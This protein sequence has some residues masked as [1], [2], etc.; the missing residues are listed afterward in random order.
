[1]PAEIDITNAA[2]LTRLLAAVTPEPA[3][4]ITADLTATAFC[5]SAA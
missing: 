2:A 5:D 1:M 3:E 4:I